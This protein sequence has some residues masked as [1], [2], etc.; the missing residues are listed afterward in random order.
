VNYYD[1][2]RQLKRLMRRFGPVRKMKLELPRL[3]SRN[4][5]ASEISGTQGANRSAE[6]LALGTGSR[7]DALGRHDKAQR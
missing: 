1:Y 5:A 7:A 3:S 6:T 4:F 2:R